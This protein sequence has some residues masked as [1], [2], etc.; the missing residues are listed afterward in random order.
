MNVV[1]EACSS[2]VAEPLMT[3]ALFVTATSMQQILPSITKPCE[4]E[5]LLQLGV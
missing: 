3:A 5:I 4:R 2:F 1:E